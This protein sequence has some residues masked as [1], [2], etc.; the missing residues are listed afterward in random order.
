MSLSLYAGIAALGGLGAV[1]RFVADSRASAR[2]DT[3][4]PIGTLLV[5]LLGAFVL[6]LLVGAGASG[7]VLR[8]GALGLLGGFTTFSTWVFESH[9]LAE[10]GLLRLAGLNIG[11]SLV[12]GIGAVWLGRLIGGLF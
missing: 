11:L 5:N 8:L 3:A 2:V 4:F 10:D 1:C 9:R 7:D 12:A 6:G